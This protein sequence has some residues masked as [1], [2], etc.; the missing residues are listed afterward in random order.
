MTEKKRVVV[1]HMARRLSKKDLFIH[2]IS[3]LSSESYLYASIL[4]DEIQRRVFS[5]EEVLAIRNS[6]FYPRL[7]G[8]LD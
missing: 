4:R 6:H 3:A 1:S 8:I 7:N 2:L 5:R